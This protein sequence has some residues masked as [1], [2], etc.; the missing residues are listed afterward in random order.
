MGVETVERNV[1]DQ[2]ERLM[3]INAYRVWMDTV[4]QALLVQLQTH[5]KEWVELVEC[6]KEPQ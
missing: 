3:E 6:K 5:G 4:V 2:F 1:V